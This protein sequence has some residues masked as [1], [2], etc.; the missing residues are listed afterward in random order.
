MTAPGIWKHWKT[1][2]LY[3]VLFNARVSTNGERE[4]RIDV[5]YM[6]LKRGGIHTRDE[7]QW[8]QRVWLETGSFARE[9]GDVVTNWDALDENHRYK[10]TAARFTFVGTMANEM[11]DKDAGELYDGLHETFTGRKPAP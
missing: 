11:S 4:G 3:R 2:D 7:E 8:Q 6:D 1:G 5:V 9:R 10:E